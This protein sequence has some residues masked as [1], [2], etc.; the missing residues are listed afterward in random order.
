MSSPH[1]LERLPSESSP[2][3]N[4]SDDRLVSARH[5]NPRI[6]DYLDHLG[7]AL[8][9]TIPYGEREALRE[10]ARAHLEFLVDEYTEEGMTPTE[11]TETALQE[12]GAP[13]ANGQALLAAWWGRHHRDAPQAVRF[14]GDM[15][16]VYGICAFGL[17]SAI[18]HFLLQSYSV[19]PRMGYLYL[20][21]VC[22]TIISPIIAGL[23]VGGLAPVNATRGVCRAMAAIIIHSLVAGML[24]LP[25][26]RGM[27]FALFQLFYW[28]PM[29]LLAAV[30]SE[31]LARQHRQ[32]EFWRVGAGSREE[33]RWNGHPLAR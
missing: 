2:E 19:T 32:R 13:D 28:L 17:F 10:E 23:V 6:E 16:T 29:G 21:L 25:D 33:S 20:P 27:L 8:L 24:L 14:S 12:Y 9:G 3:R 30:G 15:T 22:L 31:S 26:K 5:V 7:A 1:S 11:A 4:T 18:N